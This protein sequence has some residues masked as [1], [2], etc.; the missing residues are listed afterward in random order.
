MYLAQLPP[1]LVPLRRSQD[2]HVQETL[3]LR[4]NFTST[5]YVLMNLVLHV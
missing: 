5:G 2:L 4:I 1:P 3:T